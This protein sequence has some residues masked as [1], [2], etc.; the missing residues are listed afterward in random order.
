MLFLKIITFPIRFVLFLLFGVLSLTLSF[1]RNTFIMFLTIA[2]SIISMVG[3]FLSGLMIIGVI[4]SIII[5]YAS[6]GELKSVKDTVIFAL[7]SIGL[8]TAFGFVCGFMP[9]ISKKLYEAAWTAADRLWGLSKVILFC[10]T[11]RFYI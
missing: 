11:D 10:D 4:A 1:L 9:I 5:E 3:S 6:H 2:A 7:T 8:A